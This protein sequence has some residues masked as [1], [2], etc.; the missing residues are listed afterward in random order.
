MARSSSKALEP[1][2]ESASSMPSEPGRLLVS[3]EKARHSSRKA[4]TDAMCTPCVSCDARIDDD[5][6]L[7]LGAS[8]AAAG[9][10]PARCRRC[11]NVCSAA[12]SSHEQL[13]VALVAVDA[14]GLLAGG[15]R[16]NAD[17]LQQLHRR[18]RG[19]E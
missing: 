19:R 15:F 1:L 2:E 6:Q 14:M 5:W 11:C 8:G 9:H 4:S 13:D 12:T 18:V 17:V 16:Q 3:S 10:R 7:T